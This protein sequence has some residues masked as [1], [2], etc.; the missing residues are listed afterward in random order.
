MEL[1]IATL[2]AFG[3]A[4]VA[5]DTLSGDGIRYEQCSHTLN[6]P[7]VTTSATGAKIRNMPNSA[8]AEC[9][10]NSIDNP[11]WASTS[12]FESEAAASSSEG[13]EGGEGESKE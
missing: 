2:L 4:G 5:A 6:A 13:S 11:L 3:S 7:I 12:R 9:V 8:Q 10:P 1:L